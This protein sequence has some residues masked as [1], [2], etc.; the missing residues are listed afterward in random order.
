M[1]F[2]DL[3]RENPRDKITVC[4]FCGTHLI[5]RYNIDYQDG[6]KKIRTQKAYCNVCYKH[7]FIIYDRYMTKAEINYKLSENK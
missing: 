5:S 1:M 7:W 6:T 2:E 3:I 4:P